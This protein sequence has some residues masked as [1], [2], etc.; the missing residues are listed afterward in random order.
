MNNETTPGAGTDGGPL[1][2]EYVNQ[3]LESARA[4]LGRTKLIAVILILLV[5]S[6]MVF[7]TRGILGHL[8]PRQAAD[9]AKNVIAAQLTEQGDALATAI[10]ERIPVMMH[11]LPDA[12]LARI[13][14]IRQNLEERIEAQLRNYATMTAT[15]LDPLF[16]QFLVEHKDDVQ[17]FLD[18][19][20][21]LDELK[22]DLNPD[23]DALLR[24]FLNKSRDGDESLLEKFEA[25]KTLLSRIAD[26]TDRLATA[27]D[28]NEREKQTRKAIAVLLAKADFKLYE[29]TRD[30]DPEDDPDEKT[31]TTDEP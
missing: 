14:V 31:S 13:P 8:E 12:V 9:T 11:D 18:A 29:S 6:Y 26:Q 5:L 10:K 30:H 2:I 16:E 3:Q 1:A 17:S 23:M 24:D 4:S 22:E 28:L 7:V 15:E 19:A 25:S 20:Q 21:N 27:S